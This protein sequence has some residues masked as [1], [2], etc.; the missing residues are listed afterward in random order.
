MRKQPL[1]DATTPYN[2]HDPFPHSAFLSHKGKLYNAKTIRK[3]LAPLPEKPFYHS[4]VLPFV[5]LT[6]L[7]FWEGLRFGDLLGFLSASLLILCVSA[8][9][10]L[11]PLEKLA[12]SKAVN[13]YLWFFF[14]SA[15]VAYVDYEVM[16]EYG[17]WF[18]DRSQDDPGKYFDYAQSRS[19]SL[20]FND[21]AFSFVLSFFWTFLELFGRPHYLSLLNCIM[22]ISSL[23]S[24]C[25]LEFGCRADPRH[26]WLPFI[27]I[28]NPTVI[29]I[30]STLLRDMM[31]GTLGWLAVLYGLAFLCKSSSQRGS[32]IGSCVGFL[33]ATTFVYYMRTISAAYFVA[34]TLVLALVQK[35]RLNCVSFILVCLALVYVG[36]LTTENMLRRSASSVDVAGAVIHGALDDGSIGAL[37]LGGL[38]G[39]IAMTIGSSI[40]YGLPFW[41]LSSPHL[42]NEAL[43]NIGSLCCQLFTALPLLFGLYFLIKRPNFYS[44]GFLLIF[45]AW[46]VLSAIILQV[47]VRY[48]TSH[49]LPIIITIA[50]FGANFLGTKPASV[51]RLLYFGLLTV[52][53]FAQLLIEVLKGA[54]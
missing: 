38:P 54:I 42:V 2:K 31:I 27:F 52:F 32:K 21:P 46:C 9:I 3:H 39:R 35:G 36:T 10:L 26:R 40:V 51:R 5:L 4:P 20:E 23:F 17:Y 14:A 11:F 18:C 13:T 37:L 22:S 41:R 53:G 7:F 6:T 47:H 49:L 12:A 48:N 50:I 19:N 45:I 15:V 34:A 16:S 29:A 8:W 33:V 1:H 44:T 30:N 25:C 28:F 43:F 24:V